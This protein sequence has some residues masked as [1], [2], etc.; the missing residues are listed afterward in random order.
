MTAGHELIL[1]DKM[2]N[3]LIDYAILLIFH[4]LFHMSLI[5]VLSVLTYYLCLS[6]L[7]IILIPLYNLLL[8]SF[9]NK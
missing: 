2:V 5:N 4:F 9:K 8:N 1:N 3:Q 7:L 6:N